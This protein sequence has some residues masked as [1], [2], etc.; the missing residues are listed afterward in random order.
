MYYNFFLFRTTQGWSYQD[1]TA[2]D[3]FH[4]NISAMV[5]ASI[6]A[7]AFYN[8]TNSREF[9]SN[10]SNFSNTREGLDCSLDGTLDGTSSTSRAVLLVN[11]CHVQ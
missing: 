4:F 1:K 9:G 6:S 7:F 5:D 10:L 3:F 8:S 11:L 2:E